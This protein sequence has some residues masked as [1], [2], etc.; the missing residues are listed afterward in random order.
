[1][2]KHLT[3]K[4]IIVLILTLMG[5]TTYVTCHSNNKDY[6][7]PSPDQFLELTLHVTAEE[8]YDNNADF[9]DFQKLTKGPIGRDQKGFDFPS[10]SSVNAKFNYPNGHLVL[11][12]VSFINVM[13]D[14]RVEDYRLPSFT[15]ATFL[16]GKNPKHITDKEAYEQVQA[17]F[18]QLETQDWEY[19]F[20]I[21]APRITPESAVNYALAGGDASY[22][23]Y[24][25]PLSFKEFNLITS[26]IHRWYLRHGTDTFLEIEMWRNV[27]DNGDTTILFAYKFHD[28][29]NEIKRFVEVEN[30]STPLESF[31]RHF[32]N[33]PFDIRLW[34]ESKV[35]AKG[36]SI[37]KSLASHT[38][39]LVKK[40]TGFDTA[41]L[42]NTDPDKISNEDFVK[43]YKAGEDM[44]PYYET[45]SEFKP[46]MSSQ[47]QGRCL[48][49]Q[50]CP[51]S[52]YW[53]TLAKAD[54]RA[55]LRQGD[56]M[57]D[58]PNN[59]WGQVIWQFDG[60]QG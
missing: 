29:I 21:D 8:L 48:A 33:P 47:A 1:M 53:F 14:T 45:K 2:M 25:Y 7:M 24:R 36:F 12:N 27:E 18:K 11:N 39:P 23:D 16:R 50:L 20:T 52:G 38:F 4:R 51:K 46:E 57:P 6:I 3:N 42:I 30:Q 40:K 59:N 41:K 60:E 32:S 26:Y 55:Y 54:S 5:L 49:G 43:R 28:Q 13:D 56:I 35:I 37:D 9:K 58:Y 15:V 17:I 19:N 31:T 10:S 34:T 44:R 22:L